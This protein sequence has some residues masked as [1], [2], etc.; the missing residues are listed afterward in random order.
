MS[1][2]E[3][4]RGRRNEFRELNLMFGSAN[5]WKVLP[6]SPSPSLISISLLVCFTILSSLQFSL[7]TYDKQTHFRSPKKVSFLPY[8]LDFCALW[9]ILA[10]SD[11][12]QNHFCCCCCLS[13]SVSVSVFDRLTKKKY[14]F[15]FNLKIV[16]FTPRHL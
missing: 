10:L 6:R 16:I 12:S 9:P 3:R 14:C 7:A 4:E 5:V 15:L 1:G 11:F 8:P 2:R 13:V